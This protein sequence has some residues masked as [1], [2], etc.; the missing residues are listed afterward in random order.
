MRKSSK[1]L[2]L[3]I[4]LMVIAYLLI[5]PGCQQKTCTNETTQ[6]Q[7]SLVDAEQ[8]IKDLGIQ[9]HAPAPAV[10]NYIP[11]VRTGNLVFL[12][13]HGPYRPGSGYMTGKVGRDVGLEEAREA[14][15]ITA[16]DLLSSLKAEIGDLNKVTKIVKVLGV[17]NCD[18]SFTDQPKVIN[19]C[20]DLLE[21]IFGKKIGKH[22]RAAIGITSLYSDIPV[23]IEMIVEV[24][25]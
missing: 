10:A 7:D 25:D 16:I 17:V 11:A 21:S 1:V 14:A 8:R 4:Q 5:I 3:L 12:S 23:E 19:G 15:R 24:K 20:S 9:L 22:A 13:G 6:S 18:P 2:S